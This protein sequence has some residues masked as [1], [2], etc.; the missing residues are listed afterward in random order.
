MI[1]AG[2]WLTKEG[3][4]AIIDEVS[5]TYASGIVLIGDST[6]VQYCTW[7][8][9]GECYDSSCY[10]LIENLDGDAT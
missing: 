2:E 1:T 8:L 10:D 7:N 5:D 4:R 3:D 6:G 9:N